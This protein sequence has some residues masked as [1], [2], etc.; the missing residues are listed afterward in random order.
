MRLEHQDV[1]THQHRVHEQ[2]RRHIGIGV[3]TCF[4]VLVNGGLVGVGTVEQAFAGHTG[5]K[6]GQF[7]NLRDVGLAVESPWKSKQPLWQLS[8]LHLLEPRGFDLPK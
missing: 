3:F 8:Y 4:L 5:Q 6:P 1:G 2:P 7:G